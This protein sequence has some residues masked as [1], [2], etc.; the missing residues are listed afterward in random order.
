[1]DAQAIKTMNERF[2]R[3]REISLA[4]R[5]ETNLPCAL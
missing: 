5:T 4:T 2:G 3:D 1:M